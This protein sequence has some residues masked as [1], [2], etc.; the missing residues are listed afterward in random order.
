MWRIAPHTTQKGEN[1]G[2]DGKFCPP[3]DVRR[4]AG[5]TRLRVTLSLMLV[6]ALVFG[7]VGAFA[8]EVSALGSSADGSSTGYVYIRNVKTGM[9]LTFPDTTVNTTS[10]LQV[11]TYY[12]TPANSARQQWRVHH[13]Q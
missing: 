9:Y 2:K 7:C 6:L 5:N 11:R 13:G 1:N 8:G 3:C 4:R 12:G 10:F